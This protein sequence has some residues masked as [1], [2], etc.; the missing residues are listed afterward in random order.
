MKPE[1][2]SAEAVQRL[3][4]PLTGWQVDD[5]ELV[6]EFRFSTYLEGIDFVQ[7]VAHLAEAMNHHPDLLVRWR[8]VTV[9]LTTHSADGLT[10][11]DFDLAGK[12]QAV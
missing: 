1:C 12:I 6:K 5:V 9:R 2:L 3:L 4:V 10:A 7:R 8:E 11:L